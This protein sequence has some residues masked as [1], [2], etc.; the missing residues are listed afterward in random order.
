MYIRAI[1]KK[2][3]NSSKIYYTHKLID[4]VRTSN[5]PRQKIILNLGSL[6]LEKDKW[7]ALADRIEELII[8]QKR[9][10]PVEERVENLA[11]HYAKLYTQQK[12]AENSAAAKPGTGV[13]QRRPQWRLLLRGQVYRP[14]I[15]GA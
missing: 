10:T 8:G 5:G 12:L 13:R 2:N 14:G 7:K 9:L 1:K 3:K 11:L 4:S 6:N 15:R